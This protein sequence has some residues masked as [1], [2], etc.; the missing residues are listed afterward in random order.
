LPLPVASRPAPTAK[1]IVSPAP[2]T[3]TTPVATAKVT[4]PPSSPP[5]S[6]PDDKGHTTRPHHRAAVATAEPS[7]PSPPPSPSPPA[8][9]VAPAEPPR[10]PAPAADALATLAVA[11]APWCDLTIDGKARGRTPQTLTLP[12]GQHH[13]ECKNPVSGQSLVR[14]LQ[15]APGELR[16]LREWLYATVRVTASLGRGDALSL[17]GDAPAA[18]PRQV[19]P[20]RRRVTLLSGGQEIE[21]RYIDVPL[22]GCRIVDKPEL[23]CEKP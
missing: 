19:A 7:P 21:T 6:L 8:I 18:G 13:L 16:P 15:L 12:P 11:I 17:D 3:T 22:T 4:A 1:P 14:D 9:V 5:P 23:R 10:A 20:G 2:P